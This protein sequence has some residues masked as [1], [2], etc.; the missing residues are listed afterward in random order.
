MKVNELKVG[1]LLKPKSGAFFRL[2][3]ADSKYVSQSVMS[4]DHLECY[5]KVTQYTSVQRGD[6]KLPIAQH[7]IIY[8]GKAEKKEERKGWYE[9]R[10]R[11]FVPALG[12]EM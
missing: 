8:L 12:K 2:C 5:S 11:V 3:R 4:E 10:H 6:H 1:M 9:Y 7:P